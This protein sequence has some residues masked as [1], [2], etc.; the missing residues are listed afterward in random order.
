MSVTQDADSNKRTNRMTSQQPLY[1]YIGN[2]AYH[3]EGLDITGK[4]DH[5][6]PLDRLLLLENWRIRKVW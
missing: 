5:I 6:V 2:E 1:H 3:E 4:E